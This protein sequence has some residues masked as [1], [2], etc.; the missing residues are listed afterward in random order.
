MKDV[1]PQLFMV[2]FMIAGLFMPA[3]TDVLVFNIYFGMYLSY[4]L[5]NFV[6]EHND[7]WTY[8]TA[9]SWMISLVSI[10]YYVYLLFNILE[11][12]K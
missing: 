9:A 7:G 11:G 2:I 10:G 5:S 3:V 8:W 6:K 12:G 1:Y 4:G